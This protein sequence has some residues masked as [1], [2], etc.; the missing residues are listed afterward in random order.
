[1]S[2]RKASASCRDRG[3]VSCRRP[4]STVARCA[5]HLTTEREN[6]CCIRRRSMEPIFLGPSPS[7]GHRS[8]SSTRFGIGPASAAPTACHHLPGLASNGQDGPKDSGLLG[9]V[10]TASRHTARPNGPSLR[11]RHASPSL[12]QRPSISWH[13]R[14]APAHQPEK[15]SMLSMNRSCSPP[16]RAVPCGGLCRAQPLGDPDDPGRPSILR[17]DPIAD[18]SFRESYSLP[19]SSPVSRI[20][21]PTLTARRYPTLKTGRHGRG[22]GVALER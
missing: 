15:V 10:L 16:A 12:P 5:P 6:R 11:E 4:G 19:A 14:R 2:C 18:G 3:L 20:T 9:P 1:M 7:Q 13:Q 8:P 21:A 17:G 22:V